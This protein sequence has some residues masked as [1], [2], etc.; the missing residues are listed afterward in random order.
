M[1]SVACRAG[2]LFRTYVEVAVVIHCAWI[3]KLLQHLMS[4]LLANAGLSEYK[5]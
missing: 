1:I 4:C 3:S 5:K 2:G